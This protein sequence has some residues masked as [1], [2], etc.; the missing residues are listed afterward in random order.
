MPFLSA[1]STATIDSQMEDTGRKQRHS[2]TLVPF[3]EVALRVDNCDTNHGGTLF[4]NGM[5][6]MHHQRHRSERESGGLEVTVREK[7]SD[8]RELNWSIKTK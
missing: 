1:T 8:L 2:L 5:T 7:W 4:P 6:T 3:R